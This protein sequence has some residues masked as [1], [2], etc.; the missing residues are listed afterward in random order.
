[1]FKEGRTAPSV[2]RNSLIAVKEAK[3]YKMWL[4]DRKLAEW[5]LHNFSSSSPTSRLLPGRRAAQDMLLGR[6]AAQDMLLAW[7]T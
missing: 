7:H 4:S 3:S 1:V 5:G 2:V 6:R